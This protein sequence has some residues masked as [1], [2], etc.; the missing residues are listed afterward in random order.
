MALE[1][2]EL[3]SAF[4]RGIRRI[5]CRHSPGTPETENEH[6]RIHQHREI[7]FVLRGES[8]FPLNHKLFD[9]KAGD[10][11]LIDRWIPHRFGYLPS[12]KNML[13]LWFYLFPTHLNFLLHQIDQDG[14]VSYVIKWVELA[15]DL[16][17]VLDRRWDEF[18]KL[19]PQKA[20]ANLDRFLNFPLNM[21]LDEFR[22]YL[23]LNELKEEKS[24]ANN[25]IVNSIQRIIEAKNGRDCSLAQL[26]KLTGFNRFYISHLFKAAYGISIGEYINRVRIIFFESAKKRGV[27]HKQIA[28]ELGFS[29]NSSL[30]MWYRKAKEKVLYWK[31]GQQ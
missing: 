22:L 8:N 2:K 31:K 10:V 1:E 24:L 21:L 4:S 25:D 11:I 17:L 27:S 3:L 23:H 30:L 18:D 7:L 12:E 29:S 6:S 14:N 26:E 15:S 20:L 28:F 16:K 5:I 9:V 13:Y 19:S